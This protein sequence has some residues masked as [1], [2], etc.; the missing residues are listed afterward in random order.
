MAISR[1][2]ISI[3]RER[4]RSYR[5]VYIHGA[6][7]VGKS[8]LCRLAFPELPQ[9]SLEDIDTR[10]SAASDPRGFLSRYP[11]G[12]ILDEVQKVPDLFS[13]LQGIIDRGESKFVLTGSQN[14]LLMEKV[15]QSLAGRI[16][17]LTLPPLALSEMD[18]RD[19]SRPSARP[20]TRTTSPLSSSGTYAR[21]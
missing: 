17:I 21:S 11:E 14:F 3:A 1:H 16:A 5:S 18:A 12:A 8:T 7:Q 4:G 2:L 6:R 9:V 10:E 13:Y 15:T 20:S 19:P